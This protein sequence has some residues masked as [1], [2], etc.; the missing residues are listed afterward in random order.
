MSRPKVTA[1]RLE[2]LVNE[3]LKPNVTPFQLEEEEK[4]IP[5]PV[6]NTYYALC[7]L[8]R[9]GESI[10]G[11]WA[12][13][14]LGLIIYTLLIGLGIV[15]I[16]YL[17]GGIFTVAGFLIGGMIS[18]ATNYPAVFL[19]LIFFISGAYIMITTK[20]QTT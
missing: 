10:R 18:I 9:V 11:T 4:E 17:I 6:A 2:D 20:N 1:F 3:E 14:L 19:I 7:I 15:A 8:S 13:P 5:A 16:F 12:A